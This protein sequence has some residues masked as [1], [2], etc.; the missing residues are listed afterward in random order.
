MESR[1]LNSNNKCHCRGVGGLQG[2]G[3]SRVPSRYVNKEK[4]YGPSYP[5]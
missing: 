1:N 5:A 2:S 4:P 3:I